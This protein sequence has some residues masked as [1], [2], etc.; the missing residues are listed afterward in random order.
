MIDVEVSHEVLLCACAKLSFYQCPGAKTVSL[1]RYIYI[2]KTD[3]SKDELSACARLRSVL[4]NIAIEATAKRSR[5][6]SPK[7]LKLFIIS[8]HVL[9]KH[10]LKLFGAAMYKIKANEVATNVGCDHDQACPFGPRNLGVLGKNKT[11][12]ARVHLI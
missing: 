3:A 5:P 10:R 8:S 11:A 2:Y 1:T 6:T 12:Q 4:V 7:L 9:V